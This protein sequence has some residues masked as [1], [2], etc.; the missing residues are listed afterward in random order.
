MADK[1]FVG[2]WVSTMNSDK[3]YDREKGSPAAG[4]AILW[5]NCHLVLIPRQR[6][7]IKNLTHKEWCQTVQTEPDYKPPLDMN[8]TTSKAYGH[9]YLV[10]TCPWLL[11][12]SKHSNAS[13]QFSLMGPKLYVDVGKKQVTGLRLHLIFSAEDLPACKMNDGWQH[14]RFLLL[15]T[16]RYYEKVKWKSFSHICTAPVESEDDLIDCHRGT[17]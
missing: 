4:A 8:Y 12:G 2:W 17:V 10:C 6:L 9:Q 14:F 1:M 16:D 3:F 15:T 11:T 13:L 7:E 5:T